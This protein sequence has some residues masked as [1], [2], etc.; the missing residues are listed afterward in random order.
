MDWFSGST[1]LVAG[2]ILAGR[3]KKTSRLN[4]NPAGF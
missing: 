2:S 4:E 3:V 1:L